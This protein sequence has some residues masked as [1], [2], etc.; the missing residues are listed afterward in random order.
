M[1][2]SL[3]IIS[4]SKTKKK[5]KGFVNAWDLYD[6]VVFRVLKKN[7]I[8]FN[9]FDVRIISTK[10]GMITTDNKIKYYDQKMD[11]KRADELVNEISNQ[12]DKLLKKNYSIIYLCLGKVYLSTIKNNLLDNKRI[13]IVTGPIGVKMKK[14]KRILLY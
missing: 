6:G 2:K 4:C 13:K 1:N 9:K 11:K 12:F 3:L 5:L 14:L 10:Y 8:D 7:N